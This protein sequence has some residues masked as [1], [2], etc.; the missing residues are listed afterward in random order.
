M[1]KLSVISLPSKTKWKENITH[2]CTQGSA[3][4]LGPGTS[5]WP[6]KFSCSEGS[7]CFFTNFFFNK[8]ILWM[9][10]NFMVLVLE[11]KK[12]FSLWIIDSQNYWVGNNPGIS[13]V[14]LGIFFHHDVSSMFDTRSTGSDIFPNLVT[15]SIRR[16]LDSVKVYLQKISN[17]HFPT[18]HNLGG[19]PSS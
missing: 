15:L 19:R 3:Y 5:T 2:T 12:I 7:S 6:R 10:K 13:H 1:R 17:L 11:Y 8:S 4:S 16:F 14:K 18:K 9:F